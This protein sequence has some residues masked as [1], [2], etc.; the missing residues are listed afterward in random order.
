MN[1]SK[2]LVKIHFPHNMYNFDKIK[3][4]NKYSNII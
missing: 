3:V 4:Y 2:I 1:E